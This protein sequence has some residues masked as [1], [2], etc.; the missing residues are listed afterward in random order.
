VARLGGLAD[1]ELF[2][3]IMS[4]LVL[5]PVAIGAAYVGG[6]LFVAFWGIAAIG[7]LWEWCQ[8]VAPEDRRSTFA[9]GAASL[10][11]ALP[12]TEMGRIVSALLVLGMGTLGAAVLAS[13]DRR[14][15]TA[16]GVPYAGA[17]CVASILLR[18][19]PDRG[20]LVMV[21]LFAI[22]WTTD[23]AAYFVGRLIGGPKLW[24]RVSPKKTWS[25]AIAGAIAGLAAAAGVAL[26]A[27]L[28]AVIQITLLGLV[29]SVA[30]Q[31]GDLFESSMKRRF[32]AK[33]SSRIIPGH[34]GLMDRL[35]GYVTVAALAALIGVLRGGVE[36]PEQGLLLW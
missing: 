27:G 18:S 36:A 10:I 23:T 8:L 14:L 32:G 22:I 2:W 25:G 33:D 6:W 35:D 4:A 12:L 17:T 16:A 30:A 28:A 34:G 9:I 15:W 5:A 19:D 20:F 11:I 21:L 7:V 29:L 1:S 3:R 13:R 31:A 24:P 26:A